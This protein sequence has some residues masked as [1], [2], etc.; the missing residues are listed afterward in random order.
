[1]AEKSTGRKPSVKSGF[2]GL[3]LIVLSLGVPAPSYGQSDADYV[4][5][6]HRW[7]LSCNAHGYQLTT[8]FPASWYDEQLRFREER[9]TLYLGKACDASSA[10]FGKGTWCWA[11][12]GFV[13]QLE[14][15]R[16]GF[17]RQELMCDAQ[18]LNYE[19]RC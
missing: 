11:N 17:P 7:R 16:I 18:K 12:G 2:W 9:I 1:M 8:A 13:A 6:F 4:G 14:K 3:A 15:R 5:E 19:C 10:P